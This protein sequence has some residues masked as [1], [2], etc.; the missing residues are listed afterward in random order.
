[1]AMFEHAAR[2]P[3][4]SEDERQAGGMADAMNAGR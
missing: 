4:T 1:M 3:W 2:P